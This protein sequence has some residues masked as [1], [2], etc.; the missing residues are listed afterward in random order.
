MICFM[1]PAD[2]LFLLGREGELE[3]IGHKSCPLCKTADRVCKTAFDH[4]SP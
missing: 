3:G 1:Y 2:L 4:P